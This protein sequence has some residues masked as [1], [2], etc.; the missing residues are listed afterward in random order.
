MKRKNKRYCPIYFQKEDIERELSKISRTRGA[1]ISQPVMVG[2]LEDV[3]KKMELSEKNTGWEDLIFIP[4]GKSYS[5]HF[6]EVVKA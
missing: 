5:Q 6:Q 3:L 2:S 4:P 1:G